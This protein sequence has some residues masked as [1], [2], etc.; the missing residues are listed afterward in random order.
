[1]KFGAARILPMLKQLNEY[2]GGL[3]EEADIVNEMLTRC[4]NL[5]D[6]RTKILHQATGHLRPLV[7][8]AE[9]SNVS[10]ATILAWLRERPADDS[11]AFVA[12]GADGQC[13]QTNAAAQNLF[14]NDDLTGLNAY[15]EDSGFFLA[16]K[17]TPCEKNMPWLRACNGQEIIGGQVF[18]RRSSLADGLWLSF[19]ALP[20]R[21]Q[22]DTVIGA[23]AIFINVT[24]YVEM[25]RTVTGQKLELEQRILAT[26]NAHEDLNA[27]ADKLG[28]NYSWKEMTDA[29][30]LARSTVAGASVDEKRTQVLVVDDIVVNQVLMRSQ[31]T[32][33]G[34]SV[35]IAQNGL[36][37]LELAKN[38]NY[39]LILIDCDMPV[40]DGYEATKKIRQLEAGREKKAVIVAMTAFNRMGDR[41]KC[42]AAGM[43][44]YFAKGG[45]QTRL[46]KTIENIL[47]GSRGAAAVEEEMP[48]DEN[49]AEAPV[50]AG[51]NRQNLEKSYGGEAVDEILRLYVKTT[52]T[53]VDC[54]E[55]AIRQRDVWATHHYSYCIKGPTSSLGQAEMAQLCETTAESALRGKWF[56]CD[57][58]FSGLNSAFRAL[59]KKVDAEQNGGAQPVTTADAPPEL[60]LVDKLVDVLGQAT[61]VQL[62]DAYLMDTEHS[63]R[64]VNASF[65]EQDCEKLRA[66][67]HKLAGCSA[68]VMDEETER[69]SIEAEDLVKK[70]AW[71]KLML[72]QKAL[73]SSLERTRNMAQA[74]VKE[75][76]VKS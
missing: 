29:K 71:A 76:N 23:I 10:V 69:L 40:M 9:F 47:R 45:S 17:L 57:L 22:D 26:T 37:A 36:E 35:D 11:L 5:M 4:K 73:L 51:F 70:N 15:R 74:F 62:L 54:L 72:L 19:D 14:G 16:D 2:V 27:L 8:R 50:K 1:M 63:A 68:S 24:E 46:L 31:L 6:E 21:N 66:A 59:K 7:K 13:L 44:D 65:A 38:T 25:E 67:A 61:T 58:E 30:E 18:Y 32:K 33:L 12:V 55:T 64:D 49:T 43:D 48:A 28:T 75:N 34:C 53:L 56:D 60:T 42:L 3:R 41:E 39:A 20:V 52:G